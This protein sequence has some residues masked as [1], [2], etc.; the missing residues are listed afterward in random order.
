M[1]F[2]NCES[3]SDLTDV[4]IDDRKMDART[5]DTVHDIQGCLSL[6]QFFVK[7]RNAPIWRIGNRR[8]KF[9]GFD[10]DPKDSDQIPNLSFRYWSFGDRSL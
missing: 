7:D 2:L 9:V 8:D 6:V 5:F 4:P 1:I 3:T 10:W